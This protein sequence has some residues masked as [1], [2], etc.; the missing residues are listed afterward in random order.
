[1]EDKGLHQHRE[2]PCNCNH[3][4]FKIQQFNSSPSQQGIHWAWEGSS[5]FLARI[6]P[7]GTA[8]SI[9]F[10]QFNQISKA[11]PKIC[12][13]SV[14]AVLLAIFLINCDKYSLFQNWSILPVLHPFNP[15]RLPSSWQNPWILSPRAQRLPRRSHLTYFYLLNHTNGFTMYHFK[16][17]TYTSMCDVW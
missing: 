16:S 1:M 8:T 4:C 2:T 6:S 12:K 14:L 5:I 10:H 7:S 11:N 13:I 15:S 3:S 17:P 9:F